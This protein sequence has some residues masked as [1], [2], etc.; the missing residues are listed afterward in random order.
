MVLSDKQIWLALGLFWFMGQQSKKRGGRTL[1]PEWSDEDMLVFNGHVKG[2]GVPTEAALLVYTVESNLDPHASSGIAW[3]LPQ[4]TAQTLKGIDWSEPA[5]DFGKLGVADQAPWVEK[6]LRYQIAAIGFTPATALDLYVA[7]LSPL[8]ARNKSITIYDGSVK[9]Q[10][11]AYKANR[12]L[13]RSS[14]KKG[15]ITRNDLNSVLTEA[16]TWETYTRAV[17]QL[18]RIESHGGQ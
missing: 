16:E 12:G 17:D 10:A 4:I 14:P 3:G 15:Y 8:A 5:A 11:A 6:L 1:G 2:T 18:R 7:N 9:E 13:D